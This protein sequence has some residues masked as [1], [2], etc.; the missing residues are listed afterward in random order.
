MPGYP[1]PGTAA[2]LG[3]RTEN[4]SAEMGLQG[5]IAVVTGAANGIGAATARL[6]AAQGARVVVADRDVE[7]GERVAAAIRE[8]NGE[9]VFLAC[10]VAV[11]AQVEQALETTVRTYGTPDVLVN[12]AGWQL[13]KPL[14][15]TTTEEFD[16]V[17]RT[18]L[19]GM[20][21]F[22]RNA[23]R[24]MIAA[25]KGGAVVNVCS[26]FAVVGS[27]GYTAYHASKGGVA[28]FTRA[29]AVSLMPYNIRVNAVGPG[30]VD[31]PGLHSGARDTGD[32]AKG[33]QSFLDLQPL[34]RFGK[35][36]EI[37]AVI[38]FLAADE[39]GF[40]TGA[41]WMADGGYTIV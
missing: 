41:L 11:E 19:T 22:T 15:D 21:V 33:L 27:P 13:N 35:P 31:T 36:E 17:L 7:N 26:T 32:E 39:T 2:S 25:G 16:A 12:N 8:Q 23:A 28:S 40:V 9:A 14:L 18:N 37:A 3:K 29:A 34:K 6:F 24:L 1:S 20:F 4:R 38:A 5:K 30:T 10:D